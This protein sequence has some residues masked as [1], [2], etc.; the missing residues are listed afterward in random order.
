MLQNGLSAGIDQ[1]SS[2]PEISVQLASLCSLDSPEMLGW[3]LYPG[4]LKGPAATARS[5][6][7]ADAI[8]CILARPRSPA[9][10][11]SFSM[12]EVNP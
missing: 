2:S 5:V 9:V 6:D 4:L 8:S 11:A 10:V 1:T 12:L 7:L 3:G